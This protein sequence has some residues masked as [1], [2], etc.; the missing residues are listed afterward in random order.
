MSQTLQLEEAVQLHDEPKLLVEW[1]SRWSEFFTSLGPALSP[2]PARLAGEAPHGLFAYRGMLAAMALEAL[3]VLAATFLPGKLAAMRPYLP[4]KPNTYDVIYYSGEELPRTEDLGGAQAGSSGRAGGSEAHHRTQTIRIARGGSLA[5]QVVEAPNLKLPASSEAVANLL[6]I[7]PN[8]GP[9]PAEGLKSARVAL[10]LPPDLVEPAPENVSREHSRNAPLLGS[11]IPPAP[12]VARNSPVNAPVL[13]TAVIAPAPATVSSNRSRVAPAMDS[14][15][16]APAPGQVVREAQASPERM[17]AVAVIPPPVSAP[18]RQALRDPKLVLPA[19]SVIAPPPSGLILHDQR[20]PTNG[21]VTDPSKAVVPPPA[22]VS[23]GFM[24]TLLGKIIGTTDV[25]PPPPSVSVTGQPGSTGNAGSALRVTNVVPPPPSVAGGV[26]GSPR[27]RAGGSPGG[28][29]GDPKVVPPPPSVSGSGSVTGRGNGGPGATGEGSLTAGNVVPPPPTLGAGSGPAGGGRGLKGNGSGGSLDSG[30]VLAPPGGGGGNGKDS[31]VVIS[32]D[33]GT[34]VGLPGSKSGS[35]AMSPGGGDKP[36]L[37]GS[38]GGTGIGH[39]KDT[40]SG[41]TGEGP[42]AGKSGAGR[43]SDPHPNGGISPSAG[44][45]GAGNAPSGTPA[46][47]GVSVSGGSVTLPSF[48]PGGGSDPNAPGRS[49]VKQQQGP[50]ITIVA[51]SRS[52]GAFNFYGVLK[53]D[54]VYTVYLDTAL[55]TAVMQFAD[56]ASEEHPYGED[57]TGPQPLRSSLPA[58][59]PRARLVIAC[60]LDTNGNLKNLKVLEPG[61]AGMTSSVLAALPGWKFRPALR[62]QQPVEVNAILGFGIDTNDRN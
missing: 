40:G 38:G 30:S 47:P 21:T 43:G 17:G 44:P 12:S 39:G 20:T 53:G 19:T 16:I 28:S 46:V 60:I 2:S 57:L 5:E 8:P 56:P 42:G 24:S 13:E 62:N 36:G 1:S 37:G 4:P 9:P 32:N 58:G 61:P 25:V 10:T 35:L 14:T 54:R 22:Q 11:V 26:S 45:G 41:M 3:L 6:A 49:S 59:L 52:G 51:T 31:G 50:A 48:G 34:K 27:G 7:K 23:G 55:G 29:L 15:V 33:A 18:E